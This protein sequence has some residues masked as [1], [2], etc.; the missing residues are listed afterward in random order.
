M[1]G[2]EHVCFWG[3]KISKLYANTFDLFVIQLLTLLVQSL[4]TF[5]QIC[6]HLLLPINSQT[7]VSVSSLII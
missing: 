7:C 5:T 3:Y 2:F 4:V 6:L 1:W